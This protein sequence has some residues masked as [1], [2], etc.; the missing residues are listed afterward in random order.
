MGPPAPAKVPVH[1][2]R[3]GRLRYEPALRVQ[4]GL[5]RRLKEAAAEDRRTGRRKRT[6]DNGASSQNSRHVLL[7]VEHDPVYTTGIRTGAY[8]PGE[9]GRLR[10]LGAEFVRADR[11]GLITF[12]GPGQLVAYPVL[13]LAQFVP[14]ASARKALLGGWGWVRDEKCMME[15]FLWYPSLLIAIFLKQA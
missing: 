6:D 12:H 5:A 1:L 15:L 8:S 11:G 10:A 3:L 4:Q 14:A 7:S 9:E 13:D 2:W